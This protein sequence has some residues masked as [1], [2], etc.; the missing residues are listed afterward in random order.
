MKQDTRMKLCRNSGTK[1]WHLSSKSYQNCTKAK[2]PL[3]IE[4]EDFSAIVEYIQS[5]CKIF[6][7]KFWGNLFLL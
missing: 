7:L 5:M 6:V 1:M 4:C 3:H 2:R